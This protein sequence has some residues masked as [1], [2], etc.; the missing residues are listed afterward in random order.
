MFTDTCIDI[1]P[2]G[3]LKQ[4]GAG[5]AA[6]RRVIDNIIASEKEDMKDLATLRR[7]VNDPELLKII[8]EMLERKAIRVME[9]TDLYHYKDGGG[10]E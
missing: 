2:I 6:W 7:K 5:K 8:A 9:L 4:R 10:H 1:S 3:T